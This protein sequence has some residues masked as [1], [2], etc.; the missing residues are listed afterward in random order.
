MSDKGEDMVKNFYAWYVDKLNTNQG[1]SLVKKKGDAE[2]LLTNDLYKFL[3]KDSKEEDGI[4]VDYFLQAQ[5]WGE[6]WGKVTILDTKITGSKAVCTV[7]LGTKKDSKDGMVAQKLR[8]TVV[9]KKA[10]WRIEKVET[11]K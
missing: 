10:G 7:Q 4:G 6:D 8:V 2:S 11:A 3:L 5:D 9:D 1:Y